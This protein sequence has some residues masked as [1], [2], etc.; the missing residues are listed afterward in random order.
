[1][2]GDAITPTTMVATLTI[3]SLAVLVLG[4][5]PVLLGAMVTEQRIAE[6]AVGALVTTELLAIAMGSVLGMRA[7]GRFSARSVA[8]LAGLA[9]AGVDCAAIGRTGAP[10]LIVLRAL[11]GLL[12]GMLMALALVAVARAVL[13]ER[14]SG[15]FLAAQT[16][17][18]V[19]VVL[20]LPA[21]TLAGSRVDMSL[22][23]QAGS[24]IAA[25]GLTFAV[26]RRLSP[27]QATAGARGV[28]GR[29]LVALLAAGAFMGAVLS[30]WGY[31]GLWIVRHGHPA[32]MEG[33]AIA[34]SLGAQIC[35]ALLAAR[36]G[37]RLP[38]RLVIILSSL[39][40]VTVILLMLYGGN[41]AGLVYLLSAAFGILWLFT[42]PAF[43]GLLIAVDPTRRA[44][45]YV[46][47][48]QLGG[49]ATLPMLASGAVASV[50][51]DGAPWLAIGA[52][53]ATIGLVLALPGALLAPSAEPVAAPLLPG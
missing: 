8:L 1:M 53:F 32:S 6:Q 41:G 30:V 3:G 4:I 31:F 9:L 47:A 14:A 17:L 10:V 49:G 2:N 24:A 33:V 40:Q 27:P 46:A 29:S 5:E 23:I 11:A 21:L 20:F 25:A 26:P 16:L 43:T 48:A 44:V 42:L 45:L 51:I 36:L 12:E 18:Q 39:G 15:M 52:F 22:A 34:L 37:D 13:P 19:V 7:L 50:G 35:G 38:S 28:G